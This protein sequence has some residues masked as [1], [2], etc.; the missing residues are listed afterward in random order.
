MPILDRAQFAQSYTSGDCSIFLLQAILTHAVHYGPLPLLIEAGYSDRLVAAKTLYERARVLYDFGM[1]KSPLVVLQGCILLHGSYLAVKTERDFRFWLETAT[2]VA[3]Q[4]GMH[5][6]ATHQS[7]DIAFRKVFRRIWSFL[8]YRDVLVSCAGLKHSRSIPDSCNVHDVTESDWEDES[9]LVQYSNIIPTVSRLQKLYFIELVR[10]SKIGEHSHVL[11][12]PILLIDICA[13]ALFLRLLNVPPDMRTDEAFQDLETSLL[14]W[15][16]CLPVELR[17]ETIAEWSVDNVWILFLRMDSYRY[18]GGFYRAWR[19]FGR[20]SGDDSAFKT[21]LRRQQNA[22][23]EV[24]S[25]IDRLTLHELV[26]YCPVTAFTNAAVNLAMHIEISCN[27]ATTDHQRQIVH[28]HMRCDL[29]FLS[30]GT[31]R[32]PYL[33]K[34]FGL[35]RKVLSQTKF[36]LDPLPHILGQDPAMVSDSERHQ[37]NTSPA[38]TDG[39]VAMFGNHSNDSPADALFN[40]FSGIAL[41]DAAGD[42]IFE[43]QVL[44]FPDLD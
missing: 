43:D 25:V 2:R 39:Q 35:L 23:L 5:K 27:P 34:M 12:R 3:T 44:F 29:W 26:H 32:W 11:P 14:R 24:D 20:L 36:S 38:Q 4:M 10:L 7:V 30:R 1:E 42:S 18:E 41:W 6:E 19:E 16:N 40:T 13:A 15:R 33:Q 17:L 9:T 21:A 28:G 8:S 31:E 37:Y 22:M